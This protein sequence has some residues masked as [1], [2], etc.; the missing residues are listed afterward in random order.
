MYTVTIEKR[1][2]SG[3]LKGIEIAD[4]VIVHTKREAERFE[5]CAGLQVGDAEWLDVEW[6]PI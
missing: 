4:Q 5:K 1:F 6:K 3:N 2:V